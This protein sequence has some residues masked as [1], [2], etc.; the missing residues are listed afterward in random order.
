MPTDQ[1]NPLPPANACFGNAVTYHALPP[2][3]HMDAQ[4][5]PPPLHRLVPS[6]VFVVGECFRVRQ[7]PIISPNV[8]TGFI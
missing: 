5:W 8:T 2:K 1:Q 6:R 3:L 7:R 4:H